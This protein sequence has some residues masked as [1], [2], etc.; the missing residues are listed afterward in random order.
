MHSLPNLKTRYICLGEVKAS[1]RLKTRVTSR[2]TKVL[3]CTIHFSQISRQMNPLQVPQKGGQPTGYLHV[4]QK[5][6]LLGFLVKGPSL[7]PPST[8]PLERAIPHPQNPFIQLSKSP[9]DEPSSRFP[10]REARPQGICMS[11]KNLIF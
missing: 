3:R 8:K 10:K 1:L 11:L 6:H 4:S 2:F 9:V 7:R 5:P